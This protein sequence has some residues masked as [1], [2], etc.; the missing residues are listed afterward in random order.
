MR[1]RRGADGKRSKAGRE[2][3]GFRRE[4]GGLAH[5]EAEKPDR[6][7]LAVRELSGVRAGLQLGDGFHLAGGVDRA[8]DARKGSEGGTKR[9]NPMPALVGHRAGCARVGGV[10]ESSGHR[11]HRRLGGGGEGSS[12]LPELIGVL[13]ESLDKR[14]VPKAPARD[15]RASADARSS[16]SVNRSPLWCHPMSLW[17][18]PGGLPGIRNR[19]I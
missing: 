18:P 7:E 19:W 13:V 15:G 6:H 16:W 9:R 1:Y 4:C 8:L 2:G 10:K 3:K 14:P 5:E 11:S 12:V 17:E